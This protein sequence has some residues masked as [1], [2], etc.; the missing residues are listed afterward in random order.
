MMHADSLV[1]AAVVIDAA[2]TV[3]VTMDTA[4]A[5]ASVTSKSAES[6]DSETAAVVAKVALAAAEIVAWIVS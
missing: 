1:P 5:K 2:V 3:V 4:P 6:A